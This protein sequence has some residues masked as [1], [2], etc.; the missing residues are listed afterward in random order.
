MML[1]NKIKIFRTNQER[2]KLSV[3]DLNYQTNDKIDMADAEWKHIQKLFDYTKSKP[4]T[5]LELTP[6]IIQMIK[7][8]MVNNI[9]N[10]KHVRTNK[11]VQRKYTFNK[12][13]LNF[14]F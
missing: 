12:D 8:I 6:I 1:L 10:N 7:S 9:I 5:T 11:I 14:H 4:T 3:D 2:Y 13:V